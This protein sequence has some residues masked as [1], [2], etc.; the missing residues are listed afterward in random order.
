MDNQDLLQEIHRRCGSILQRLDTR[1]VQPPQADSVQQVVGP[2]D[3]G[4]DGGEQGRWPDRE[5]LSELET[6]IQT[7]VEGVFK[8]CEYAHARHMVDLVAN[9]IFKQLVMWNRE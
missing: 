1:E 9:R 5:S 2:P 7:E 6:L 8:L 4:S 3:A